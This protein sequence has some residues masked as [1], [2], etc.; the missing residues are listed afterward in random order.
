MTVILIN[1]YKNNSYNNKIAGFDL[2]GTL[3]KTKSGKIFATSKNDWQFLF[4]NVKDKLKELSD[5]TLVVFSNQMGIS[6]GRVKK[7]DILYKVNAIYNQLNIPFIFIASTED[8][9]NRKPRIGMF[10]HMKNELKITIDKKNSF[11]VGDMAGR[12]KDKEDTDRKF[13]I[14][15]GL[16]FYTPEEYF[17]NKE[18]EEYKLKGYQLDY[19][20]KNKKIKLNNT[21]EIIVLSGYPGSGKSTLAN[22][23]IKSNKNYKF[24]SRDTDGN[25]FLSL[26]ENSMKNNNPVIVEGLFVSNKSR[27]TILDLANKYNYK[28]RLVQFNIDF[29]TAYHLNLWRSLNSDSVKIPI[30]AYRKY[31]KDYENPIEEIWDSIESYKPKL[32]NTK[33]NTFYLF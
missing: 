5:Y 19:T 25:K 32:D 31:D 2:D 6:K 10:D 23:L 30:I 14:N 28:K 11:F 1:Y 13:A 17:L 15:L 26:L 4:D 3:I 7:E 27:N 21:K 18:K 24:F 9:I 16:T 12:T 33:I 20:G 22:T 29:D 8:D